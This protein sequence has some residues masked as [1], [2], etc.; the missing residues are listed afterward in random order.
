MAGPVGSLGQDVRVRID[1]SHNDHQLEVGHVSTI[2][3][4]SVG[5]RSLARPEPEKV[6]VYPNCRSTFSL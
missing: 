2:L 4:Q 1:T 3:L 5:L 6:L